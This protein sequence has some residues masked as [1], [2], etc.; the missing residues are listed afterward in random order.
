VRW[1]L[2]AD[3]SGLLIETIMYAYIHNLYRLR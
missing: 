1:A 3:M 2:L